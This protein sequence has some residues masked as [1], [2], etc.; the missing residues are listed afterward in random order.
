MGQA[1]NTVINDD[2]VLTGITTDG[3][4]FIKVLKESNLDPIGKKNNDCWSWWS[5]YSY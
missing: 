3:V 4:G 5:S 1:V 2:G